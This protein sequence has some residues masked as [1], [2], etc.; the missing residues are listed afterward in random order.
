MGSKYALNNVY[1][2]VTVHDIVYSNLKESKIVIM[3]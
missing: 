2:G 3:T 1:L